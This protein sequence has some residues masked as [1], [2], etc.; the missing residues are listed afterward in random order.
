MARLPAVKRIQKENTNMIVGPELPAVTD[1]SKDIE[2]C[3]VPI[4]YIAAKMH[5]SK[6]VLRQMIVHNMFS[7]ATYR[8]IGKKTIFYCSSKL[9]YE[10]RGIIYDFKQ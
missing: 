5:L 7:F 4:E 2:E 3:N 6:A 8:L 1:K 10:Q 9:L